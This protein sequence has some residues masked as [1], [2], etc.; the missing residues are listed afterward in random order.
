[1][2]IPDRFM[3]WTGDGPLNARDDVVDHIAKLIDG[4]LADCDEEDQCFLNY[5]V[6]Y[7]SCLSAIGN[8]YGGMTP[9]YYPKVENWRKKVLQIFEWAWSDKEKREDY[10]EDASYIRSLLNSLF[11]AVDSSTI[12]EAREPWTRC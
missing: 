5:A 2:P 1:M 12:P 8:T 6:S 9:Q 4:A 7:M 3:L 11:E 10:N